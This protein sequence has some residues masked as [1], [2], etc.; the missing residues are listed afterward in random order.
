MPLCNRCRLEAKGTCPGRET[1]PSRWD[2]PQIPFNWSS[3]S[4]LPFCLACCHCRDEYLLVRAREGST[5]QR[6]VGGRRGRQDQG[7]CWRGISRVPLPCSLQATRVALRGNQHTVHVW[8]SSTASEPAEVAEPSRCCR[9]PRRQSRGSSRGG[10]HCPQED[11]KLRPTCACISPRPKALLPR[12]ITQSLMQHHGNISGYS[13]SRK[14]LWS[15]CCCQGRTART[16]QW[17]LKGKRLK[18]PDS[19]SYSCLV[20][21]GKPWGARFILFL[22]GLLVSTSYLGWKQHA[23]TCVSPCPKVCFVK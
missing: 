16:K 10:W 4:S 23:N 17:L 20:S 7:G 5:K 22:K 6:F 21:V 15:P 3:S 13:E 14:V 11:E 2:R 19:P 1:T 9:F 18:K 12:A 8:A